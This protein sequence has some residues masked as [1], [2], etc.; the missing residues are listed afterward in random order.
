MIRKLFYFVLLIGLSGGLVYMTFFPPTVRAQRCQTI[1][2]HLLPKGEKSFV[3]PA[4]VMHELAQIDSALVGKQLDSIDTQKLEQTFAKNALFES[5][6]CYFT[7]DGTLHVAIEQRNPFFV[8]WADNGEHYYVAQ[9]RGIIPIRA[10]QKYFLRLLPVS[11]AVTQDAAREEVY[12]L[13]SLIAKDPYWENFFVQ[14]YVDP[15]QGVIAVPRMGNMSI[16]LGHGAKWEEK[17]DKL[18]LFI[19]QV[20]PRFGWNGIKSL[21]LEYQDQIV[22]V[23]AGAMREKYPIVEDDD[24]GLLAE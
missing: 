2:V 24:Q 8:V 17:L 13:L 9:D 14:L 7:T 18:K 21:N 23:P 16:V 3:K 11:G 10:E 1:Q 15:R 20:I 22:A 5:V 19:E 4:D 12:N 6:N